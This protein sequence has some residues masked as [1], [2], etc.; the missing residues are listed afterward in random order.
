M[1][2]NNASTKVSPEFSI[3]VPVKD[4]VRELQD[5]LKSIRSQTFMAWECLL[6]DDGST[7]ENVQKMQE[8]ISSD[9]RF[10]FIRRNKDLSGAN[11]CRN[12]GWQVARAS[13]V[14]FLDSDDQLHSECLGGR[15]EHITKKHDIDLVI[16]GTLEFESQ[17]GDRDI[18]C[19]VWTDVDPVSRFLMLDMPWST[20]G[21]TWHKRA[22]TMIDGW[23]ERLQSWQDWDIGIRALLFGI[24]YGHS[25]KVDSYW[26]IPSPNR[27]TIGADSCS[28]MHTREHVS[29]VLFTF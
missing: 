10:R 27:R 15:L 2:I 8:F 22:L 14:I 7:A 16:S 24:R 5:T 13:W 19:N 17:P 29:L 26:R 4:R 23:D 1:M 12:I 11:V 25:G 20:T 9:S 6:V 3:V 28:L 21:V 18:L